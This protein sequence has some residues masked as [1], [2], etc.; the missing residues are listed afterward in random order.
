VTT[1]TP[2]ERWLIIYRAQLAQKYENDLVWLAR[3][4]NVPHYVT[5]KSDYEAITMLAERMTDGLLTGRSNK[6]SDAIK[7]TCKA[8]GI[9]H[10]YK[11][12]AV[13]LNS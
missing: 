11:A 1:E 13:F 7:A 10:T 2:R 4:R 9:K 8:L 6:D 12:I 3:L 5:A